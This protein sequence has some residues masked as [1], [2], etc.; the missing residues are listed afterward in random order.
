MISDKELQTAAKAYEKHLLDYLPTPDEC[1]ATFSPKFER[2]MKK[3]VFRTDHPFQYMI[4]KSV[5]CFFLIVF[6]GGSSLLAFSTETRAIIF[7]WAH[8]IYETFVSYRHLGES[9]DGLKNTGYCPTWIPDGYEIT[10]SPAS[11]DDGVVAYKNADGKTILFTYD[12]MYSSVEVQ[13]IGTDL[14][15]QQVSVN[16]ASADL[17]MEQSP[18]KSKNL[19]W[20]DP[21]NEVLFTITAQISCDE[22]IKMAESVKVQ[23]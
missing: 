9:Q 18:D 23:K 11:N 14:E 19:I 3:L 1:E 7:G 10:Q 8:E 22:I 6:L 5:I 15:M 16:G 17:Y 2:K 4:Q 21:K 12:L 20:A 13:I